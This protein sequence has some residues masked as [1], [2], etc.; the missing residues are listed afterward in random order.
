MELELIK[1]FI[2]ERKQAELRHLSQRVADIRIG[3]NL[4]EIISHKYYRENLHSDVIK[5]LLSPDGKHGEGTKYLR[6]FINLLNLDPIANIDFLLFENNTQVTREEGRRDITISNGKEAIIIE[7]KI[8][9]ASDTYNQIPKYVDDLENNKNIKVLLIVYLPLSHSKKPDKST[10]DISSEKRT[11]IENKLITLQAYNGT[12]K[13]LCNGWLANCINLTDNIDNLV[14]LRQYKRIIQHLARNEMDH[15]HMEEFT[16]YLIESNSLK[17]AIAIKNNVDNMRKYIGAHFIEQFDNEIVYRPFKAIQPWKP[18]EGFIYFSEYEIA[19]YTFS[20]D[21]IF[22]LD[23]CY[24]DFSVRRPVEFLQ[25]LPQKILDI[26][27][28]ENSFTWSN[29]R[30]IYLINKDILKAEKEAEK[31]CKEFFKLL[32]EN[33]DKITKEL[34]QLNQ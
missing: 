21:I 31:F 34:S 9:N 20:M 19:G 8:Y 3:F 15:K 1:K 12:E 33:E 29:G 26:I 27:K 13:D 10:W 30:Y 25:E 5:E 18:D 2:S 6:L 7:N 22:Y 14:V 32:N 17:V 28:M 24:I 23:K 16:K 11:E 4:F